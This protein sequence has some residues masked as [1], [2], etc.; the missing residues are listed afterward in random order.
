[1][2]Q[3]LISK[4]CDELSIRWN[5]AKLSYQFT[6]VS[7]NDYSHLFRCFKLTLYIYSFAILFILKKMVNIVCNKYD[8]GKKSLCIEMEGPK[9]SNMKFRNILKSK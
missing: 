2:V 3:K 9:I 8:K 5:M 4:L 6:M 1:M 7:A